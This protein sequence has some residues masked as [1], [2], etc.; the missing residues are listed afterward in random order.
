MVT[1]D[2]G[3]LVASLITLIMSDSETKVEKSLAL[4]CNVF[5]LGIQSKGFKDI[6]IDN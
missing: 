6:D 1:S 4:S 5:P 3:F 2:L